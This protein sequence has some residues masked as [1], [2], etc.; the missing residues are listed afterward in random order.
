MFRKPLVISF[1]FILNL[2]LSSYIYSATLTSCL[3]TSPA[4]MNTNQRYTIIMGVTNT[5]I[6]DA[7]ATTPD[8]LYVQI[9]GIMV[10][11]PSPAVADI[12]ASG[13]QE[14]TW[15]YQ[16][17]VVTGTGIITGLARSMGDASV[18]A[19][20]GATI[21][22]YAD[23]VLSQDIFLFPPVVSVGQTITIIM[24]VTNSGGS[25]AKGVVPSS[26]IKL[27][28]GSF[29]NLS[30]P[31]PSSMDIAPGA[32]GEFTWL[33]QATAAGVLG[34][35]D[36]VTGYA[37]Y[38][39][40]T[41]TSAAVTSNLITIET[42]A[43]II[44][45]LYANPASADLGQS[46]TVT[47]VVTNT[48]Q[49]AAV[50]VVPGSL[51]EMGTG[52]AIYISGPMPGFQT[53]PGGNSAVFTWGYSVA[54][55]GII[56]FQGGSSGTD[57][58]S[59]DVVSCGESDSNIVNIQIPA[60]LVCNLFVV[61]AV[62]GTGQEI[63]LLMT[64]TNTG[65]ASAINVCPDMPGIIGTGAVTLVSMPVCK[66]IPGGSAAYFTWIYDAVGA[67]MESFT[68]RAQGTDADSGTAVSTNTC[69]S[70]TV[71]IIP[72]ASLI[73]GISAYPDPASVGQQITVIMTV[74]N[75]GSAT[76]INV[77]PFS[78][79]LLLGTGSAFMVSGPIP[80]SVVLP[81]G[82]SQNF[83][84]VFDAAG[85]GSV[86]FSGS[87]QG[88]DVGTGMTITSPPVLDCITIGMSTPTFTE[89]PT[90]QDTLM[91]TPTITE[92]W[93][94]GCMDPGTAIISPT[95]AACCSGGNSMTITYTNGPI[96]WTNFPGYGTLRITI[97]TGWSAPSTIF[98]VKG[99]YTVSVVN[100]N[101]VSKSISGQDIIIK[102]DSLAANTGQIVVTYGASIGADAQCNSGTAAFKVEGQYSGDSTYPIV[103]SPQVQVVCATPTG[104]PSMT[105]T[106]TP[107][108]TITACSPAAY[109]YIQPNAA[110]CGANVSYSYRLTAGNDCPITELAIEL[111]AGVSITGGLSSSIPGATVTQVGNSI[112]VSY[113]A[114]WNTYSDPNFDM[115]TF[116]SISSPGDKYFGCYLNGQAD[117]TGTT[118]NGY[119]Q[120]VNYLC[121]T[122]TDTPT[123]TLTNTPFLPPTPTY[124]GTA[125]SGP[126]PCFITKWGSNGS[127][128]G[129]FVDPH[130]IAID[131]SGN[132]Y[133]ADRHNN[134]IQ[135]FDSSGAYITQWGGLGT[136]N[137]QFSYPESIAIDSGG[138]IY[139]GETGN[140][141][142]QVFDS[143]GNYIAQWGSLGS[144]NGQFNRPLAIAIDGSG[145]VFVADVYNNRIQK[146]TSS[147]VYITQWGSS[148]SGNGQFNIPAGVAVDNSGNVYVVDSGNNRI[149]EFSNTGAFMA[150]ISSH[151]FG[152][153]LLNGPWAIAIDNGGNLFVADEGNYKIQKFSNTGAY[154][155]Q[156]GSFG[157]GDG[158]FNG[159]EG[160]AVDGSGNIYVSDILNNRVQKFGACGSPTPTMTASITVSQTPPS[161]CTLT[162]TPTITP[163]GQAPQLSII[164]FVSGDAPAPGAKIKY[165]LAI[166][167]IGT[168]PVNNIM[169][170][171]TLPVQLSFLNDLSG[172]LSSENGQYLLWDL[173]SKPAASPLAPGDTIYVDFN[174]QIKFINT[175]FP[176]ANYAGC[177]YEVSGA[178]Y[179]PVFSKLVFYP[180][181]QPAVY[182]NPATD[183][184][185][186]MNIVPG[187]RIEIYTLSAE[188]VYS[189]EAADVSVTWNCRNNSG[190]KA[191]PGVY[192]YL[193]RNK[194][195]KM[196][197]RGKIFIIN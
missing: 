45:G 48:G 185:K 132:V 44:C 134:R 167:N 159:S 3:W 194:E 154:I 95:Q 155:T 131:S 67:G 192:Y 181:D 93:C 177:D 168:N 57:A 30:G 122:D 160:I 171:D 179:A 100:G 156:W 118:P 158:Q 162:A 64:V 190:R 106:P 90:Q 54:G 66:T 22:V 60:S 145:N 78:F 20:G 197:Y 80:F 52:G 34:V 91:P 102:V 137:G 98:T 124:T 7:P 151:G 25:T 96:A 139:V 50:N 112:I 43:N 157:I 33:Y 146:F 144:G 17:T 28:T 174:V 140:N 86:C 173:S 125:I 166:R 129:Q 128:A 46:V 183:H 150:Q 188:L 136:G 178:R 41:I 133:V 88:T 138:N 1:L 186:F 32:S 72:F 109:A 152:N 23:P 79:S 9:P 55:T 110:A 111:Q 123:P 8:T 180:M 65:G 87:A 53:I 40:V 170:W 15:V 49:A 107:T 56:T 82:T 10:S 63:T 69:T 105:G 113:A 59:G 58:N 6:V 4:V 196:G 14:F 73:C 13:Y 2:L 31:D 193:I 127:G 195:G 142:I 12:P 61:P 191:S 184:V 92:T 94:V 83:T 104:T 108:M 153:G 164:K 75:T 27:G 116:D 169:V 47:M 85:T 143:A 74:T 135:K 187:S 165:E 126:T 189:Q 120:I 21:T 89:T 121:G 70:N 11:G 35:N 119:S 19:C 182:P 176:I 62:A 99:Y 5:G 175:D 117:A 141:R 29:F 148:G 115:I 114:G 149:Q 24:N 163:I 81:A 103:T 84:W 39:N 68:C 147:G 26:L 77:S 38:S 76:A 71:N 36:N 130:G 161:C 101:L 18:D 16:T 172:A 37:Q 42:P 51:T 97:P